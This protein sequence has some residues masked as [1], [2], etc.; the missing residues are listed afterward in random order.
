MAGLNATSMSIDIRPYICGG[1]SAMV[2]ESITFPMDTAKIRLQLQGNTVHYKGAFHAIRSVIR[3]EGFTSLYKGLSPALLRQ[4]VY[5]TIKFGLYYT[6]KDAYFSFYPSR[7]ESNMVNLICAIFAGSVSSA[8]ANPTD[9]VKV[10]MQ[11]K[12]N[13]QYGNLL[14]VF[15]DIGR[16]EG[17]AG[18]WRGVCPTAQRSAIVAGV[19]L[20]V[21]DFTRKHLS[22][23]KLVPEG[24]C[25]NLTASILA[26][27]SAC[28]ASNPVDVV[29]T[30]LMVQ[31]RYLKENMLADKCE[32]VYKSS[33][34]CCVHTVRTEGVTALYKGFLP[35]FGRMGPWNVVFFLVY[36]KLKCL[37]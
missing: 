14:S 32:K 26:G 15:S 22:R 33:F 28:L 23:T 21:Y 9:V 17:M 18:M 30:R 8:I 2:A 16:K 1:L 25:C 36:E 20:P 11:A 12:G 3:D 27:L 35:S 13:V 6:A 34:E 31:R 29:R 19:Q 10:R 24:A 4:A 5:G 7:D 37:F